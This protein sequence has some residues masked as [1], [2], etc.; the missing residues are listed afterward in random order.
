MPPPRSKRQACSKAAAPTTA[1]P[2]TLASS[3]STEDA[4]AAW[5]VGEGEELVPGRAVSA[6]LHLRHQ[7]LLGLLHAVLCCAASV[8]SKLWAP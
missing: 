7:L 4:N 5:A 1:T 8:S 6:A 2:M 3:C